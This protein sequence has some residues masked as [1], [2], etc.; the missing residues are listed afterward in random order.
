M[1]RHLGNTT[2]AKKIWVKSTRNICIAD[3]VFFKHKYIT[4]PEI[5]KLDAIV[6]AETLL[7]KLL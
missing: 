1:L 3:T 4:I 2:D 6:A 5:T 7:A